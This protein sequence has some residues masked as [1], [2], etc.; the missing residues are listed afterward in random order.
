MSLGTPYF[1]IPGPG[2][3]KPVPAREISSVHPLQIPI[4]AQGQTLHVPAARMRTAQ[5][6]DPI[7]LSVADR[8]VNAFIDWKGI[9]DLVSLNHD[10]DPAAGVTSH[11]FSALP[12]PTFSQVE[13]SPTDQER[14]TF[15]FGVIL[16][17]YGEMP[18]HGSEQSVPL[19]RESAGLY[20][21]KEN[22]P[23]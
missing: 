16:G 21:G 20:S 12:K 11:T 23:S 19:E 9:S 3:I 22:V 8:R 10:L 15:L 18:V 2:T 6:R 5:Q 1:S 7:V 14:V 13:R 17:L 4:R